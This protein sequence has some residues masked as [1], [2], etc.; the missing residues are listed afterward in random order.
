MDFKNKCYKVQKE[1][2][3][4]SRPFK[5]VSQSRW[6][7]IFGITEEERLKKIR[8]Y[9]KTKYYNKNNGPYISVWDTEKTVLATGKRMSKRE[10]KEYCKMNGKEWVNA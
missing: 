2:T 1:G 8:E 7:Q 4:Y 5:N 3:I 9:K 10:L 6:E